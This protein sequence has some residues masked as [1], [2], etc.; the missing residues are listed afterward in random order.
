MQGKAMCD[1]IK[2]KKVGW[3]AERVW[4]RSE[5]NDW[6]ASPAKTGTHDPNAK[7]D[8]T[9]KDV[10]NRWTLCKTA[11]EERY[12]AGIVFER[13]WSE[14]FLSGGYLS[15]RLDCASLSACADRDAQLKH[16]PDGRGSLRL[17][18]AV[19]VNEIFALESH[20]VL[21]RD[22]AADPSQIG[23]RFGPYLP[24]KQEPIDDGGCGHGHVGRFSGENAVPDRSRRGVGQPHGI[25]ALPLEFPHRVANDGFGRSCSTRSSL[26]C[27]ASGMSPISSKKIV[28]PSAAW[29]S[30]LCAC[31]APENAPRAWPKSSDSSSGSGIAPQLT[32][33]NGLSPRGLARWIARARSSLP[34]PESP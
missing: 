9:R 31:T 25:A 19:T 24:R 28:P 32:A 14:F 3:L 6:P 17:F 22:A 23:P 2:L 21:N 1:G 29:N 16:P 8:G 20:P 27:S 13:H 34:V 12:E 7:N 5:A 11:I 33:T 30:P 15:V 4:H 18:L 26:T 10:A